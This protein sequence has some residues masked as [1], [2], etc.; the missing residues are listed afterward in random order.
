[1]EEKSR[2]FGTNGV[3][4]TFCHTLTMDMV[5]DLVHSLAA[6]FGLGHVIIGCD[7]RKSSPILT[8]LV[9]ATLL[10]DGCE[11]SYA[12]SIPTPCLQYSTKSGVGIEPA[13]ETS[14][15]S[16]SSVA[17][18]SRVKIGLDFLPS[19]PII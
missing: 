10:S 5:I 18:T 7:G 4:G 14:Q 1:M 12:G 13:L 17:W 15:P 6:Y 3:R 19:H 2:L 11:V 9:Q 8:R 16:E